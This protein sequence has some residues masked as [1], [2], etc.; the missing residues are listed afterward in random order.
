MQQVLPSKQ[1]LSSLHKIQIGVFCGG[2][3]S[4][5]KVSLRSGKAVY[6]ALKRSGMQA[7]MVDP[8]KVT[9]WSKIKKQFDVAFLA[10][11]GE[12]GED[13]EIQNR[14]ARLRIPF[15][16]SDASSSRIA[17]DK[18]LTKIRLIQHRVPTPVFSLIT[19]RNYKKIISCF[20]PPFFV[21]PLREGSSIGVFEITDGD[22]SEARISQSLKKYSQLLLE[23]TIEGPEYTVG[24]LGNKALPVVE[25]RPKGAFYDYHSKYTKGMTQYLV[26]APISKSLANRLQRM[27]LKSHR[28][29]K[30]RDL[31]RIDFKVDRKTGGIFVLEANSIPGFTEFSLLPKAAKCEGIS[32][33]T[34]CQ[35][36]VFFAIS[37]RK[38]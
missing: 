33:E 9:S 28:A 3:S 4:E 27:A 6:E 8:S 14:L 36:L 11:H 35:T 20:T 37:R 7:R 31:S 24:I 17:F 38:N 25:M 19:R 18:L 29:L 10:L 26:P 13:G 30:L 2:T 1:K 34:L 16:G 22:V 23:R 15:T 5:K 21:K 32:F 12:G